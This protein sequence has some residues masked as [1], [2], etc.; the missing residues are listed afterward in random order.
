MANGLKVTGELDDATRK[1]MN[2]PRCGVPDLKT[3]EDY[4]TQTRSQELR[5]EENGNT[6]ERGQG[7]WE[8]KY[9][10][11]KGLSWQGKSLGLQL[12]QRA[13][14]RHSHL[15][16]AGV[17]KS[18]FAKHTVK[19]RL[20]GE[21]YSVKL[22]VD[23]QR[24]VLRLA[25]RIWSEVVPLN[26]EEDQTSPAHLIDIKLGF[27]TRRHLGCSQVF[28]GMGREFAHAWQLGDIH[29]NDDEHFVTLNSEQG[30]SLLKVAV[31]EIGHVRGLSHMNQLGSVMQPNYIPDNT[32]TELDHVDRKAIQRIY[33]R[34]SGRFN[35]VFDWVL[36][37]RGPWGEPVIRFYTYFFRHG[38]YW[39]YEN[40]SN[41]TRR[42]DPRK[43]ELGW[44][45]IPRSDIDAFLQIRIRNKDLT[46]FFKGITLCNV[47]LI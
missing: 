3:S 10:E 19:W 30:I 26:F 40:H 29:F 8:S 18:A 31:H 2:A 43:V 20:L 34:C 11:G 33:G 17:K 13:R 28:D 36:Q 46:L 27:G 38:W 24:Y 32:N 7:G 12:V 5:Q 22:S 44:T 16:S 4:I 35:T 14:R 45:G 21:G 42:G 15:L 41:R 23:Q 39:R 25:S 6:S 9:G 1:A 47:P 37:E